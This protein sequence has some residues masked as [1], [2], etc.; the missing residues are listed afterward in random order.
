MKRWTGLKL[1]KKYVKAIYCHP[2][3]LTH[4]QTASV[5]MPDWMNHK[6]EPKLLGEISITSKVQMT[7]LFWQKEKKN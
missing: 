7:P 1:R 3:N 4:M 2:A 5:E 6:P